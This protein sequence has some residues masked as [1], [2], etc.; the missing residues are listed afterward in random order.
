MMLEEGGHCTKRRR[1]HGAGRGGE[2]HPH[3]EESGIKFHPASG[4]VLTVR[5]RSYAAVHV[6]VHWRP[7]SLRS[8]TNPRHDRLDST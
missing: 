1:H 4:H 2:S 5:G 7:S 8:T 3:N 6:Q